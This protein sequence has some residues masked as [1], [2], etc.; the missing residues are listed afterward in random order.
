MSWHI[1]ITTYGLAADY[2]SGFS[3][4]LYVY[5]EEELSGHLTLYL[6]SPHLDVL[7]DP[8]RAIYRSKSLISVFTSIQRLFQ[9]QLWRYDHA[10]IFY[11]DYSNPDKNRRYNLGYSSNENIA[12]EETLNPYATINL[13]QRHYTNNYHHYL[14]LCRNNNLVH[15]TM[16]LLDDAYNFPRFF[17]INLYKIVETIKNDWNLND[18]RNYS[19][20]VLTAFNTLNTGR[21][22]GYMNHF[23]ASGLFSRHGYIDNNPVHS[24]VSTPPPIEE[25]KLNL[26]ILINGWMNYKLNESQ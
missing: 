22:K 2:A 19:S 26:L 7:D 13:V 4:H 5:E 12:L 9:D 16:I 14:S 23:N 21:V 10:E 25:T 11:T 8:I 24:N 3:N 15:T 17:Y 6:G 20:E 18:M 1:K